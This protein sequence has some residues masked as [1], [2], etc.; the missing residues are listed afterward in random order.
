MRRWKSRELTG[1]DGVDVAIE[2]S[3]HYAALHTAIR[4]ARFGGTVCQAGALMGNAAELWLGREFLANSLKM[5]VPQGNG[6]MEYKPA[7]YP[8]VGSVSHLRHDCEQN[9][10]GS[11][12]RPRD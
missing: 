4:A 2:I 11:T 5:I 9:E 10:T 1:G 3:G 8:I 12:D 6:A 7:D